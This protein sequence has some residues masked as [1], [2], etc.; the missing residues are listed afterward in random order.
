MMLRYHYNQMIGFGK[1]YQGNY[2]YFK[3]IF[4]LK[5]E[6]IFILKKISSFVGCRCFGRVTEDKKIVLT[7]IPRSISI[8]STKSVKKIEF[9]DTKN[10]FDISQFC[11]EVYECS[12]NDLSSLSH[13]K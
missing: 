11:M 6:I 9:E 13:L 1:I 12:E 4:F 8:G 3:T 5:I 7:F 10:N 2:Y